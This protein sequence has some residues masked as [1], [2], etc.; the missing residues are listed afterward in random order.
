[1]EILDHQYLV[2]SANNDIEKMKRI[3]EAFVDLL[4]KS[5]PEI[6]DEEIVNGAPLMR[7]V[8]ERRAPTPGGRGRGGGPFRV[9]PWLETIEF[10]RYEPEAD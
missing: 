10:E 6:S 5:E 9:A 4:N 7:R 3:A 2:A 1:M 8:I